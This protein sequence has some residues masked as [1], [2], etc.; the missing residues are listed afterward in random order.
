MK[1][2]LTS[3]IALCAISGSV[4][5]TFALTRYTTYDRFGNKTG[6]VRSFYPGIVTRYDANG[7]KIG[8]YI[9]NRAYNKYRYPN[10]TYIPTNS[11]M[12]RTYYYNNTYNPHRYRYNT[13][14]GGLKS[15]N[16]FG[17]R[18]W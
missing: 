10:S 11:V 16:R 13:S 1:K 6:S 17:Q 15:Y 4:C 12:N 9:N 3:I 5:E 2:L 8:T 14:L 7:N 18:V